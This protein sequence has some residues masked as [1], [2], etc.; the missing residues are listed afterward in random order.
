MFSHCVRIIY[1]SLELFSFYF[2]SVFALSRRFILRSST[3]KLKQEKI[4]FSHKFAIETW[5][6]KF[7]YFLR[8][9]HLV[10]DFNCRFFFPLNNSFTPSFAD[11]NFVVFDSFLFLILNIR[12]DSMIFYRDDFNEFGMKTSFLKAKFNDIQHR[13][14]LLNETQCGYFC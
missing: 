7:I 3:C 6:E 5:T 13:I 1:L 4:S 10:V 2:L 8:S 14:L 9:F 12:R 11:T